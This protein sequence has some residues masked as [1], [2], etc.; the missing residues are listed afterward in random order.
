MGWFDLSGVIESHSWDIID[1]LPHFLLLLL[2][3]QRFEG[4]HWGFYT[5]GKDSILTVWEERKR[6]N[7]FILKLVTEDRRKKGE[8]TKTSFYIFPNDVF[9][10]SMSVCGRNT[11]VLRAKN[12]EPD[13]EPLESIEEN[14]LVMKLC[15][16][17]VDDQNEVA[18]LKEAEKLAQSIS[19]IDGHIPELV[20]YADLPGWNANTGTIRKFLSKSGDDVEGGRTM[21]IMIFKRLVPIDHLDTD[22][23]FQAYCDTMFCEYSIDLY[24]HDDG[25]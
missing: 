4:V 16:P 23:M 21:R 3:F 1:D 17:G 24:W 22:A 9:R 5:S 14:D 20:A 15:W 7:L 6:E 19:L 12:R 18:V 8:T 11:N 13:V 25:S 2:I 10:R